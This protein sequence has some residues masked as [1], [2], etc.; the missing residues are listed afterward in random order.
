MGTRAAHE[1][2][3]ALARRTGCPVETIRYYE[4]AGL[5]PAP[6]RSQGGYR[7]YAASHAERLIFIRRAR[8]LG[9]SLE[10]V[11]ALLGLADKRRPPCAEARHVAA[12]H[13]A[14]IRARMADLRRMA[15]ALRESI[16]RC[17]GGRGR[18]CPILETLAGESAPAGTAS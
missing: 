12:A 5:L 9:F 18:R 8:A 4:R 15:R 14:D 2:I 3:G 17:N 13:L 6:T 10:E 1:F 11:R 16:A 7:L